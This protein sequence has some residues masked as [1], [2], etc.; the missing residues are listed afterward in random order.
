MIGLIVTG[1]GHFATGMEA[2][3]HVIGGVPE[4]FRAV[5][6]ELSDSVEI[7]E[8]KLTK[9][10]DDLAD[11]DAI[12]IMADLAGGSPFKSSVE[13]GFPKGNVEVVAGT[14]M[15][16]LLE[17]NFQ[18]AMSDDVH[19]LAAQAVEVAKDSVRRFELQPIVQDIPTDGI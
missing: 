6:F 4:H 2:G 7:L 12:L 14:N 9:A 1:H 15:G 3:L 10:M 11:C 16:M 17:I 19:A 13:L 5:D 18:R 8:N